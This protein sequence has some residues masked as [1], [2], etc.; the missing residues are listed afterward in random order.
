[1][2]HLFYL[3]NGS[4]TDCGFENLLIIETNPVFFSYY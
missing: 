2:I 1:M 4:F 3:I